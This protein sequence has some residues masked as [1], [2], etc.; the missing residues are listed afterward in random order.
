LIW[1]IL[2]DDFFYMTGSNRNCKE[3]RF[4]RIY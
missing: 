3:H 2:H 1:V 4:R